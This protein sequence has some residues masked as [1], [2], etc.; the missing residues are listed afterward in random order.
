MCILSKDY[1]TF[2]KAFKGI[3]LIFVNICCRSSRDLV[4][5]PDGITIY[6]KNRSDH[7][8]KWISLSPVA[9][10]TVR[11]TAGISEFP[12]FQQCLMRDSSHPETVN[13][14]LEY[15]EG[16]HI[17]CTPELRVH[18]DSHNGSIVFCDKN[19]QP[20]L[21]EPVATAKF[22]APTDLPGDS[23]YRLFQT[24]ESDSDEAYYG[25]GQP[26][27]GIFNYKDQVVDLMQ[28]NSIVAVPF[29]FS[30][31]NYGIL[32]DN[33]SI[34]RVGDPRPRLQLSQLS[35]VGTDGIRPGLTCT[36]SDRTD[37]T[38]VYLQQ[39]EAVIDYAYLED[40]K[41]FPANVP[42]ARAKVTWQGFIKPDTTGAYQ[43]F[44]S[45]SGYL[46][47]IIDDHVLIDRW[48]EGWNPGPSHFKQQ[49]DSGKQYALKVEWIPESTQ[50]FASLHFLPPL[51]PEAQN[52]LSI[53]SEAGKNIDYYFIY[54]EQ[55]DEV[56][57]GY[58]KLTGRAI[59]LP[60]VTKLSRN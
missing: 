60:N 27:T 20:I 7:Q 44:L 43:F 55:A 11:V 22:L 48:R 17:L 47:V 32:W 5:T 6:V 46:R 28:C 13:W 10:K 15:A 52:K 58:R 23:L 21:K 35:P 1:T 42:M 4:R 57:A 53:N 50:A 8:P 33:Y 41:R 24:F 31:K 51:P 39:Q 59:L 30:S 36:Y 45:A 34:T 54:G 49:L 29:I 56:I 14:Q 26:Q 19:D 25:L 3:I 37:S 16:K 12:Q 18:V 9:V 38:R 2:S 40:L